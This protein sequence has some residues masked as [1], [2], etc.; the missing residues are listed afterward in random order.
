MNELIRVP[1]E[2]PGRWTLY[3]IS[4]VLS[5]S[6]ELR[7]HPTNVTSSVCFSISLTTC[8][9]S[10]RAQF[11]LVQVE[12][13]FIMFETPSVVESFRIFRLNWVTL[14]Y[15]TYLIV[16]WI[17]LSIVWVWQASKNSVCGCSCWTEWLKILVLLYVLIA[18]FLLA[19]SSSRRRQQYKT[20]TWLTVRVKNTF[21]VCWRWV[22]FI[23]TV[24]PAIVTGS[25]FPL[26]TNQHTSRIKF[27]T[28]PV[29]TLLNLPKVRIERT[30]SEAR[31]VAIK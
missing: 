24:Y 23:V 12:I 2:A 21:T 7:I 9:F 20:F 5:R 26:L 14:S 31:S 8:E 13:E 25:W 1:E 15:D 29:L 4:L 27:L 11:N 30:W 18:F 10:W 22:V 28:F 17:S 19:D 16:P 6:L 3:S